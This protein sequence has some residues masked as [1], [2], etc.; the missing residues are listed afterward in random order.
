VD[1]L[2]QSNF[3]AD[4]LLLNWPAWHRML[5]ALSKSKNIS[6]RRAS[7][8][9]LT[10]PIAHS[11]DPRFAAVAFENISRLSGERDILITKAISWLL[12]SM[13]RYHKKEVAAFLRANAETLPAIAVRETKRKIETGRK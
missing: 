3:T 10:G 2:C 9:L 5:I 8:V 13:V 4:E 7:L 6:K 1:S 11:A 12:R